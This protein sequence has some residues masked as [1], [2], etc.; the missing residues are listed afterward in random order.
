MLNGKAT[1]Y[2]ILRTLFIRIPRITLIQ[3]IQSHQFR[4]RFGSVGLI[5]LLHADDIGVQGLEDAGEILFTFQIEQAG[6]QGI[7]T[8]DTETGISGG[9][10]FGERRVM[11]WQALAAAVLAGAVIVAILKG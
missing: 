4:Q 7:I 10:A 2:N 6:T 9:I 8:D 5:H 3:C 11:S 1:D